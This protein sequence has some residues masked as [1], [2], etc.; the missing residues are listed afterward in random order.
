MAVLRPTAKLAFLDSQA[1]VWSIVLERE[2]NILGPEGPDD[3]MMMRMMM[4][5][6]HGDSWEILMVGSGSLATPV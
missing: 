4:M 5:R 6:A 1:L 2:A 3:E